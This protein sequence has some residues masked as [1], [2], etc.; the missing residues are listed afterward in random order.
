MHIYTCH[1][2]FVSR[3]MLKKCRLK[4]LISHHLNPFISCKRTHVTSDSVLSNCH[5]FVNIRSILLST[6]ARF[7]PLKPLAT[8]PCLAESWF[9]S[10]FTNLVRFYGNRFYQRSCCSLSKRPTVKREN[11]HATEILMAQ[12]SLRRGG[13]VTVLWEGWREG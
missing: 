6:L 8:E 1:L 13:G 4:L 12:Y 7:C 2:K 5:L 9:S 10:S 3:Y 11:L